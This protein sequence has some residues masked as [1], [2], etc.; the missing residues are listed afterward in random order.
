MTSASRIR[1]LI[2]WWGAGVA[3]LTAAIDIRAQAG[4]V[5]AVSSGVTITFL[6]NEGVLLSSGGQEVLI[7]AL[8]RKYETGYAIPAE[9]TLR[10]L[11]RAAPPFASVDLILVTHR[12][13]DH[14]HPAPVLDHLVANPLALLLTSQQVI[15]SM[16]GR[17]AAV[18]QVLPRI[19]AG[20]TEPRTR[21][22][23]LVNGISVEL[24]GLPHGGNRH[25]HVEHLGFIVELGGTRVLHVG[26]TD[27]SEETFRGFRLDTARIDVALLPQWMVRSGE[28][29]E[30][31]ERW[32]R[33]RHV[34]AFHVGEGEVDTAPEKVRKV[35]P[36]AVTFTRSLERRTW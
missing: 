6:A 12:H 16:R 26:D 7:D 23:R 25:R 34:V 13:G 22:R 5:P 17:L 27:T 33:P 11:E 36:G 10:A 28:G 2:A 20:T 35:F 31:I 21:G 30:V 14:F 24:L 19:L 1:L 3:V 9:S 29:R 4:P 15:D 18:P 32:I 8:F